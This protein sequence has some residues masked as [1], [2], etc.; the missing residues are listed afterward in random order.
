MEIEN[1]EPKAAETVVPDEIPKAVDDDDDDDDRIVPADDDHAASSTSISIAPVTLSLSPSKTASVSTSSPSLNALTAPFTAVLLIS[2]EDD[3]DTV[4]GA[5]K[6]LHLSS[7][8]IIS[9]SPP[10]G[11]KRDVRHIDLLPYAVGIPD[12]TVSGNVVVA[13]GRKVCR[14]EV[15]RCVRDGKDDW[16]D[17][18]Q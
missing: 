11:I 3:M 7:E 2:Y 13:A 15:C 17:A 1:S 9:L 16:K 6:F 8:Q 18:T 12:D 10:I 4:L 5:E 14:L